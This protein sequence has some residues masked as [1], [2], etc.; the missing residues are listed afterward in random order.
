MS[1]LTSYGASNLVVDSGLVV[2]YSARRVN[3]YWGQSSSMGFDAASYYHMFELARSARMSFRYIGMTPDA[4]DACK[5]AM[6]A[7]YTRQQWASEWDSFNGMWVTVAA[8]TVPMAE[9]AKARNDDG[10]YD[11]V[12]NVNELDTRMS[13]FGSEFTMSVLF[14][15]EREREYEGGEAETTPTHD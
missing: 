4:A 12:V 7:K 1:L 2:T 14:Y 10:S 8:G 3:G 9:V 13:L 11:V 6:V 5:A 15:R